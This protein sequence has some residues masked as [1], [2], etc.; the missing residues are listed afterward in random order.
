MSK[1]LIIWV[2]SSIAV[3]CHSLVISSQSPWRLASENPT[4]LG[5]SQR[6]VHLHGD[7]GVPSHGWL[8]EGKHPIIYDYIYIQCVYIYICSVYIIYTVHIKWH[9]SPYMIYWLSLLTALL[10]YKHQKTAEVAHV[11]CT[12]PFARRDQHSVRKL[13]LELATEAVASEV[14]NGMITWDII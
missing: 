12:V 5:F 10:N 7:F 9:T 2:H 4:R 1:S 11:P 8:L 3:Y 6:T 13:I 14:E